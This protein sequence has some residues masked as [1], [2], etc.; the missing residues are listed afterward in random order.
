MNT[1]R[2]VEAYNGDVEVMQLLSCLLFMYLFVFIILLLP[3]YLALKMNKVK[4]IVP[5][6]THNHCSAVYPIDSPYIG[7]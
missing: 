3:L 5:T 6:K 7:I 1:D 2:A 4:I